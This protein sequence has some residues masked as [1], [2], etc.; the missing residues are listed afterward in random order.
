[1]FSSTRRLVPMRHLRL[2]LATAVVLC[3]AAPISASAATTRYASPTGAG[4]APCVKAEPCSIENALSNA[5]GLANGDTVLLAPG[6]YTP[7]A[8][9]DVFRVGVTIAGEPG[10][11]APLIEVTA[12]RGLF[13]QNVATF[14]DL[15]IR[16]RVRHEFR[17]LRDRRGNHDRTGRIDRRSERRLRARFGCRPEHRLR[18]LRGLRRRGAERHLG[19]TRKRP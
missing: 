8:D 6:T 19:S 16:F 17:A 13:T 5:E 2:A 14:Q 3:L 7:V 15:R 1:M 18:N 4:P 10:S 11:P 9:L 12:T